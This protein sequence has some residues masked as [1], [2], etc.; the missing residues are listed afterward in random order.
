MGGATARQSE[1]RR[2]Q[3]DSDVK[4]GGHMVVRGK[5]RRVIVCLVCTVFAVGDCALASK[6]SPSRGLGC[7]Q[8]TGI[9][10]MVSWATN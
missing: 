7:K 6:L 9:D 4:E 3:G 10:C 1:E 5:E 2:A 8:N